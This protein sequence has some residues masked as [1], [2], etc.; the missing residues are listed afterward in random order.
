[1]QSF[2]E[3]LKRELKPITVLFQNIHHPGSVIL[4]CRRTCIRFKIYFNL[5]RHCRYCRGNHCSKFPHK[6]L[7]ELILW[8]ADL[9]L[10]FRM[11][12]LTQASFTIICE[13][14]GSVKRLHCKLWYWHMSLF[15][16]IMITIHALTP[17]MPMRC[18]PVQLSQ[19]IKQLLMIFYY[20]TYL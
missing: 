13:R 6:L 3:L 20:P 17:P 2:F 4:F 11:Q 7:G 18:N 14:S 9:L 12:I 16:S 5:S 10:C 8:F 15:L 1:M 19:I